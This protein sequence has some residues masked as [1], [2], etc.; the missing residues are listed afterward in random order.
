[1]RQAKN[2]IRP[3]GVILRSVSKETLFMCHIIADIEPSLE[4][5]MRQLGPFHQ[6]AGTN[7]FY[8]WDESYKT[9]VEISSFKDVPDSA[10][11]RNVAFFKRLEIDL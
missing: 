11:A 4:K 5:V 9:F 3:D 1:M 2:A 10:R 7:C 8:K 6:K